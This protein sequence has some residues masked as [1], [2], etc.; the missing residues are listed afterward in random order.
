[1]QSEIAR[2]STVMSAA[3]ATSLRRMS[4][5]RQRRNTGQAAELAG[6]YDAGKQ[7]QQKKDDMSEVHITPLSR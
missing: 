5:L 1:M 6:E 7:D 3:K 4:V 2:S